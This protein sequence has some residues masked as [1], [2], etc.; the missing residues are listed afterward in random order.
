MA[1]TVGNAE[2]LDLSLK[3]SKNPNILNTDGKTALHLAAEN[4]NIACLALLLDVYGV[5][6]NYLAQNSWN[7][8]HFSLN[9]SDT[10]NALKTVAYL[11]EKGININYCSDENWTCLHQ[12]ASQGLVQCIKLLL[13]KNVDASI[14]D[15]KGLYAHEIAKI[16]GHRSC[17]NLLYQ[18]FWYWKKNRILLQKKQFIKC[19][20]LYEKVLCEAFE[21]LASQQSILGDLTHSNWLKN[22]GLNNQA[23][24]IN[25]F[26]TLRY[27]LSKAKGLKKK[28]L[29]S[30]NGLKSF[31]DSSSKTQL[32]KTKSNINQSSSSSNKN[33]EK[34]KSEKYLADKVSNPFN[35]ML[36]VDV[37]KMDSVSRNILKSKDLDPSILSNNTVFDLLNLYSDNNEETSSTYQVK[38][39]KEVDLVMKKL[40]DIS[41]FRLDSFKPNTILDVSHKRL[42]LCENYETLSHLKWN[43]SRK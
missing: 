14:K 5:D 29:S 41:Y 2:W 43:T 34:S 22:K 33:I 12:A 27:S 9:D 8:L 13:L 23:S 38:D 19:K 7:A 3:K 26:D 37:E 16:K 40:E 35:V 31:I 18:V 11:I 4:H 39:P 17:Y 6:I 10:K 1:A 28:V 25:D 21:Q 32:L 30:E 24:T 42:N 20:L 36:S 15:S